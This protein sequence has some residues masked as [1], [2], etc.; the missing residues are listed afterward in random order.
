M[1][2]RKIKANKNS[3]IYIIGNIVKITAIFTFFFIK[4]TK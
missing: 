2:S 3:K 1:Y 4:L